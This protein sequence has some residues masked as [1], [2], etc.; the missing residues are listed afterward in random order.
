MHF[1]KQVKQYKHLSPKHRW[2]LVV[3]YVTFKMI[4]WLLTTTFAFTRYAD[5]DYL[6]LMLTNHILIDVINNQ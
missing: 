1:N 4:G 2:S 6:L 5:E 3:D